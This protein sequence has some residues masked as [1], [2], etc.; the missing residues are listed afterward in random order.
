MAIQYHYIGGTFVH[1]TL[2]FFGPMICLEDLWLYSSG[3]K[4]KR[5]CRYIWTNMIFKLTV[6]ASLWLMMTF[7]VC[8]GTQC[9]TSHLNV[10]SKFNVYVPVTFFLHA[11]AFLTA[12]SLE[13]IIVLKQKLEVLTLQ[14][15]D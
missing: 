7:L 2:S 6:H 14:V 12:M 9:I 3:L 1:G 13:K 10:S 15:F 11:F 4:F 8:W 5:I